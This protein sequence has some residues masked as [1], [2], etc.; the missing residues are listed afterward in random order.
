MFNIG[1]QRD[2]R[3]FRPVGVRLKGLAGSKRKSGIWHKA[4]R[5]KKY[6]IL[7]NLV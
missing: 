5:T 4:A 7:K 3:G 6:S 2:R 1:I